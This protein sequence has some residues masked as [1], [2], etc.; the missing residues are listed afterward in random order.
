MV[1]QFLLF[2][3]E[4]LMSVIQTN[5]VNQYNLEFENDIRTFF[6]IGSQEKLSKSNVESKWESLPDSCEQIE[7]L[8]KRI[9]FVYNRDDR[10]NN[11]KAQLADAC[12][13]RINNAVNSG[14]IIPDFSL[15]LE[16]LELPP[17]TLLHCLLNYLEMEFDQG[18]TPAIEMMS[19]VGAVAIP[20]LV[21]IGFNFTKKYRSKDDTLMHLMLSQ[22][23]EN[24]FHFEKFSNCVDQL[25]IFDLNAQDTNGNT[26]VHLLMYQ[27]NPKVKD[28]FELVKSFVKHGANFSLPN[29]SKETPLH[30][31][32]KVNTFKGAK[33]VDKYIK[34]IQSTKPN[35]NI[36][37][38]QGQLPIHTVLKNDAFPIVDSREYTCGVKGGGRGVRTDYWACLGGFVDNESINTQDDDGNTPMHLLLKRLVRT[39]REVHHH[40]Q[41]VQI[42]NSALE[43]GFRD[44]KFDIL[45]LDNETAEDIMSQSGFKLYHEKNGEKRVY[46]RGCCTIL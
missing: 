22:V 38:S 27:L 15:D 29:T 39:Y 10:I 40:G 28:H 2:F 45:N 23:L 6:G 36:K 44:A 4:N 21:Q 26:P 16:V 14:L 17:V 31:F 3:M 24:R 37:N 11:K 8:C 1:T 41:I 25:P 35:Y 46:H 42:V 30:I 12:A 20:Q 13:K 34:Y 7:K 19:K 33:E 32:C 18:K 43:E 5:T 9:T